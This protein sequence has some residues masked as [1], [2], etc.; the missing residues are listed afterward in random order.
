MYYRKDKMF[1]DSMFSQPYRSLIESQN[2]GLD[3]SNPNS[4]IGS[5]GNQFETPVRVDISTIRFS[6]SF[7]PVV[8]ISMAFLYFSSIEFSIS[9][10]TFLSQLSYAESSDVILLE[11]INSISS[12]SLNIG[13]ANDPQYLVG[14]AI[15]TISLSLHVWNPVTAGINLFQVVLSRGSSEWRMF[16]I[17]L[18]K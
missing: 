1:V 16:G 11:F 15:S 4:V 2:G 5:T 6:L 7:I 14:R 12:A 3:N 10:L 13:M 8:N 18:R 9:V 17:V